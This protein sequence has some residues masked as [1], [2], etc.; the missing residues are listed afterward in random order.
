[1]SESEVTSIDFLNDIKK[2][3]VSQIKPIETMEDL[4]KQAMIASKTDFR[5]Q[6]RKR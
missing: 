6:K 1:M 2:I 3:I 4:L 5:L